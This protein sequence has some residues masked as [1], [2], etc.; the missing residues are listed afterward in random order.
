MR[1][2]EAPRA[3]RAA[4]AAGVRDDVDLAAGDEEVRGSR[5][6]EAPR[7]AD[8]LDLP[9]YGEKERSAGKPLSASGWNRSAISTVPSRTAISILS[10]R[11]IPKS[12]SLRLR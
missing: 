5:F 11:R 8:V 12:G 4:S 9:G 1:V 2:K 10:V 3:P 7:R 6:D